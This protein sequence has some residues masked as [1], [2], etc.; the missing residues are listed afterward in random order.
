MSK[1]KSNNFQHFEFPKSL[2]HKKL[3]QSL[4]TILAS[5]NAILD[6][7]EQLQQF[8]KENITGDTDTAVSDENRSKNRYKDIVPYNWRSVRIPIEEAKPGE[9]QN[10]YINASWIVFK[11][12]K[13][14][15]I[16]SQVKLNFFSN[17]PSIKLISGSGGGNSIRLLELCLAS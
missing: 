8:C 5:K 12:F 16:A 11:H 17:F 9:E 6:E 4:E 10:K 15:F 1:F 13:Q 7:Y 14:N 2:S 3:L